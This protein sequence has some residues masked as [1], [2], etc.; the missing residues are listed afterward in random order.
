VKFVV[1]LAI[2]KPVGIRVVRFDAAS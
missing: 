1:V 2:R